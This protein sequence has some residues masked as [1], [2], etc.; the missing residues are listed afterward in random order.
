MIDFEYWKILWLLVLVPVFIFLFVLYLYNR[1]KKIKKFADYELVENLMKE[2]SHGRRVWKFILLILAFI[3]F[4]IGFAGPK[5]GSKLVDK[6]RE[7]IE[8]I[9]A[10]D[11]SK[12]MLAEDLKP[13]RISKAKRAVS[14]VIDRFTDDRI[15]L[16]VFAGDAYVQLPVTSDYVSAKMFL[17]S[18]N[19][20]IV[21]IPGTNIT[22]AIDMAM[23]SYSPDNDKNKAL[24]I[25]SDGED[26]SDGAVQ[27]AKE[28][29]D[30][31]IFVHTIGIGKPEGVPIPVITKFGKKEFHL[32]KDGNVVITR[33]NETLLKQ[34]A[35]AGKG[36]YVRATNVD[37]GLD[38][39]YDEI[40]KMEKIKFES[41][42]YEDY[43]HRFQYFIGF[44]IFLLLLEFIL[45]ERKNRLFSNFNIFKPNQHDK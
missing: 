9:I 38:L 4:V 19:P 12:S 14:K 21:P 37:F 16:I 31:G 27:K 42:S 20:D 23:S 24:I 5:I 7:G 3:F 44:A 34:I 35:A 25:I 13:N 26:H 18:I 45:L 10:L 6:K 22:K 33:L 11:V 15:G 36:V 1:K 40:S 41:K 17:S 2:Y 32:D 30:K 43:E 28:A 39:I 8:M 29:A